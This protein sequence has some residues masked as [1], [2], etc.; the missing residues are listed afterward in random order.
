VAIYFAFVGVI[1]ANLAGLLFFGVPEPFG[2]LQ[3]QIELLA[4][5]W[6]KLAAIIGGGTMLVILGV[7]DD[8]KGVEFSPRWKLLVQFG[9]A[10]LAVSAGVKVT[11]LP[12][13]WLDALVSVMWIV[14]LTNSFNLLD[15]MDGLSAGV[16]VISAAILLGVAFFQGQ[17]FVAMIL[18]VFI[19]S[20]LGFL[21]YNYHPSSIFM[22][23]AGS[24]FIGYIMS[25]LTISTS[26][27]T[28]ASS[29]LIPAMMPLVILSIPIFDTISVVIIR[30]REHRPI[31]VGD[32]RH[33]SHRLVDMGFSRRS[34]VNLIYLLSITLGLAAFLLPGQSVNNSLIIISQALIII[35]VVSILMFVGRRT[36]QRQE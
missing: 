24:L 36:S 16:A 25:T 22:G 7:V 18:A 6:P 23:D 30:L 4:N 35:A 31:Y 9:A 14:V 12:W 21:K 19:G 8:V 33:L 29:S 32:K 20:V 11:F 13:D 34:A 10:I 27:V 17:V 5:V 15:N 26:Y 3:R 28:G 1:A 2:F